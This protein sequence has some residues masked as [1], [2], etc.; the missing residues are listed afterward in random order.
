M[1][2]LTK[3]AKKLDEHEES[4]LRGM[5]VKELEFKLLQLA[6]HS[7]EI[8]STMNDDEQYQSAKELVKEM[9]QP[10]RE[11]ANANKLKRRFIHL[12]IKEKGN[13][14]N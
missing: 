10:Y 11:Q 4:Q 5:S 13:D 3:L 7:E 6:K 14:S 9:A 8:T 12:L 1:S 2:E